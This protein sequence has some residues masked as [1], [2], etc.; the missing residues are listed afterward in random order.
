MIRGKALG[1]CSMSGRIATI[2]L[3]VVGVYA[4]KWWDGNGLYI[5]FI[6]MCAI[7]GYGAFTMPYCTSGNRSIG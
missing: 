1:I 2:L 7:S 6:I 4:I 3:G 5:I